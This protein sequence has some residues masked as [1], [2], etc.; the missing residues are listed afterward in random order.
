MSEINFTLRALKAVSF[1]Q[2]GALAFM[3]ERNHTISKVHVTMA[4]DLPDGWLA[5]EA[6]HSDGHNI[7][8]GIS[9]E[10]EVST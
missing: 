7:N 6:H 4:F 9:P 10:G 1:D 2:I 3:V 8:G 5:F